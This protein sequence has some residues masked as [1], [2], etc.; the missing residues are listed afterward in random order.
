MISKKTALLLL[1]F[2]ALLAYVYFFEVQGDKRK[3]ATKEQEE[4]ILQIDRDKASKLELLPAKITLEKQ[5]SG[6]KI[7]TPVSTDADQSEIDLILNDLDKLKKGRFVS[8]NALDFKKFGLAP[9]RAALVLHWQDGKQDSLLLGNK[10]LDSTQVFF[11]N[12]GSNDVYLIPISLLTS[13]SKSLYD[14][15]DKSVIKFNKGAISR[16][17]FETNQQTFSCARNRVQD[18]HLEYPIPEERCDQDKINDIF[19]KLESARISEFIAETPADLSR[20]GLQ[21]P[22]LSVSLL[23]SNRATQQTLF[24]GKAERDKFYART[25][26]RPQI[27]LIDSSLVSEINP[28]LFELRDKT[29]VAFELDSISEIEISY[30]QSTIHFLKDS[31]RKWLITEPDSGLAKPWKIST[32]LYDIK[33]FRVAQFVE[34]PFRSDA[35]YGFNPPVIELILKQDGAIIADL[36]IGNPIDNNVFLKN[37]QLNKIYQVK[38]TIKEKLQVD[39]KDY[40]D[41]EN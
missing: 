37:K 11:R 17:L 28:S 9:F 10:N 25:D 27:F 2:I 15:R 4:K 8:D 16:L 20:Y 6:W 31:T 33:D 12:S 26:S 39:I 40:I 18:W 29:I 21:T 7:L 1:I 34:K 23:D 14:L 3:Q 19:D 35:E 30:E 36:L 32:L 38:K 24:I 22:G 13:I 5:D 41:S